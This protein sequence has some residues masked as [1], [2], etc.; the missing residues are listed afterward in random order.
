MGLPL[1]G[2]PYFADCIY[3]YKPGGNDRKLIE[4]RS[5]AFLHSALLAMLVFSKFLIILFSFLLNS[6]IGSPI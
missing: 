3:S 5:L 1:G 2:P 4:F 6:V